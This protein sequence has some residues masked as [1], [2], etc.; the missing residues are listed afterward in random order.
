MWK[1][2]S[3]TA[4]R[5]IKARSP[6]PPNNTYLD[7]Y[8]CT[9]SRYLPYGRLMEWATGTFL[10]LIFGE[11]FLYLFKSRQKPEFSLRSS[12]PISH[13]AL[14]ITWG[15]CLA[16]RMWIRDA[17]LFWSVDHGS[18]MG[19]K[20]GYGSGINNPD[21]ISES[22]ETMYWVKISYVN[23]L[24]LIRDPGWKKFV[25][26][27]LD[28][29]HWLVKPCICRS[30]PCGPG[31]D[32]SAE[33]V[34]AEASRIQHQ[35]G[36]GAGRHGYTN[37]H[38][39]GYTNQSILP[40]TA[41]LRYYFPFGN[42]PFFYQGLHCTYYCNRHLDELLVRWWYLIWTCVLPIIVVSVNLSNIIQ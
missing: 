33:G 34:G 12:V 2:R 15:V 17:V 25:S 32:Y 23:S 7:E 4:V 40:I 27:I 29:Q 11:A 18:G 36:Q 42:L 8:F 13:I 38:L 31:Q 26:G 20:S 5:E 35:E 30:T 39:T 6:R 41:T 1:W 37:T 24:M 14:E 9:Y 10:K 19:K 28:P 22:L 16:L 21:H 3:S